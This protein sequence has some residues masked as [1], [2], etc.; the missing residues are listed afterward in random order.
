MSAYRELNYWEINELAGIEIRVI[1]GPDN[2]KHI[3]GEIGSRN[4][5][6]ELNRLHELVARL[7]KEREVNTLERFVKI[8][9]RL[10][11]LEEAVKDGE[12]A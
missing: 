8:E 10:A 1:E 12:K 7:N 5:V 6:D 2:V 11:A 4:V 9:E 3:V